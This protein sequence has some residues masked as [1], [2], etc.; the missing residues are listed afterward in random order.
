MARKKS[1]VSQEVSLVLFEVFKWDT[2]INLSGPCIPSYYELE[3][4]FR[5]VVDVSLVECLFVVHSDF[6]IM[7]EEVWNSL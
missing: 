5:G 1:V 4:T 7:T 6:G 2:K 3:S